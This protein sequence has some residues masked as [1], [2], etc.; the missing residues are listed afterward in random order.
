MRFG[1]I[2]D[3]HIPEAGPHLPE[4]VARALEG[5]DLILHAGD[6]HVIDVIDELEAIAPVIAVRG[7]GDAPDPWNKLRPGV[8]DDPRVHE[9]TVL[10]C[11]GFALGVTHA[12][13][14]VDEAPWSSHE[15]TMGRLFGEK[16]DVVVCGDTHVEK[17]YQDDDLFLVNPGSPTLPHNLTDRLGTVGI[18]ELNEG[19]PPSA[20]IIDLRDIEARSAE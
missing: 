1:L 9:S 15:A 11:E 6:M 2:S 20:R 4:Q 12:F 18:L 13:P 3:T 19:R 16:V 8:P 5:V 17:I 7:N 14:T 10:R